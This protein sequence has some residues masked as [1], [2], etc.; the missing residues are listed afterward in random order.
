MSYDGVVLAG[1][2]ARRLGGVYKPALTVGGRRLLDI[3]LDALTGARTTI[4]VGETV[5]TRSPVE[6]VREKPPG[7]GPVE[8]LATALGI[9][10][11][12]QVVVL[13]ADLPFISAAAVE[14]LVVARGAAPASIAVDASGHDQPLIGC[15]D[16]ALLRAALPTVTRDAS[17]RAVLR[18]L[19]DGGTLARLTMSSDPPATL[20]CDTI[21]DLHRAEELA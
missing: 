15:Y 3:A 4:V 16:T 5:P 6:W 2:E 17:M 1:G 12:L 8:A 19:E 14:A 10:R 21:D 11:A 20:D 7:G 9:V 13:A 18:T